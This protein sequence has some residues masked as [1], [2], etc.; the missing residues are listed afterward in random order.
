MFTSDCFRQFYDEVCRVPDI[1]Q[2]FA[3]DEFSDYAALAKPTVLIS[4]GQLITLHKV[5]LNNSLHVMSTSILICCPFAPAFLIF[6]QMLLENCIS[7]TH[8]QKADRLNELLDDF[9]TSE[10]S[11][12]EFF[13]NT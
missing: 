12:N 2:Y 11:V 3:M 5:C 8:G 6:L 7:L 10:P 9:G 13:G 1:D 4:M